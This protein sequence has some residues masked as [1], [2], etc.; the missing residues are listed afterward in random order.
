MSIVSDDSLVCRSLTSSCIIGIIIIIMMM[1]LGA[2]WREIV[3]VPA[4]RMVALEVGKMRTA[5]IYHSASGFV[6]EDPFLTMAV[7]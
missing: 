7:T 5:P 4:S 6:S 3:V 2:R 1:R